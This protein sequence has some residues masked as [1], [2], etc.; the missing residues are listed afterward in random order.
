MGLVAY[1]AASI[2][3]R[4]VR[5]AKYYFRVARLALTGEGYRTAWMR[6]PWYWRVTDR[7]VDSGYPNLIR[8]S[9]G[10][11]HI[12]TFVRTKLPPV[13]GPRLLPVDRGFPQHIDAGFRSSI[14]R[15]YLFSKDKY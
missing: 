7:G 12:W 11:N 5:R 15:T 9:W 4:L 6:G 1:L 10:G 3:G 13:C 14:G 2:T 8:S